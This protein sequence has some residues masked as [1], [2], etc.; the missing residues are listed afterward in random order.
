MAADSGFEV[1]ES[2][3][4]VNSSLSNR[5]HLIWAKWDLQGTN[6]DQMEMLFPWTYWLALLSDSLFGL[7]DSGAF[8]AVKLRRTDQPWD[9]FADYRVEGPAS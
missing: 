8:L 2:R 7:R 3:Y 6:A 4:L 5:L 9:A 1:E